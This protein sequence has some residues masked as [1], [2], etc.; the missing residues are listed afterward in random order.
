MREDLNLLIEIVNINDEAHAIADSAIKRID[1][2]CKPGCNSCCHQI[3]DVYT[4]EEPKIIRAVHSSL[5]RK[6]KKE[7]S[8][9][10]VKWFKIF[11][12]NT[13][14][15]SRAEPLTF[16]D[17]HHVQHVFRT[18]RIPC[19]FLI[20]SQCSIYEARPLVCRVHYSKNAEQCRLD[21]HKPT[22]NDAQEVFVSAWRRYDQKIYPVAAKPLAY[23]VAKEFDIEVKSKPMAALIYDPNRISMR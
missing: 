19:P 10:L 17:I 8:K 22:P 20:N 23:L 2:A 3:V 14:P 18:K 5:D 7:V 1:K 9:S 11:N 4:W 6:E 16:D 21:P 15:A 13:P 12:D